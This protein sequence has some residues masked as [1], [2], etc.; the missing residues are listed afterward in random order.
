MKQ[1][2]QTLIAAYLA[3]DP[4]SD[5]L[6]VACRENPEVLKALAELEAV[7]R[8]LYLEAGEDDEEVFA[9]EVRQRLETSEDESFSQ[10][11]RKRLERKKSKRVLWFVPL[12][13][14]AC[15]A[16]SYLGFQS[17]NTESYI[18]VEQA[19]GKVTDTRDAEWLDAVRISGDELKKGIISLRHGYSEI[20][21][22]NGVI[23]VLEAPVEIEIES[24]ALIRLVKGRLVAKVPENA[25]GFTVMTP[26]SEIV[27][28]GTEF[29]MS[30]DDKGASEVHVLEGEV[31]ARPLYSKDF[32]H[33]LQNEAMAFKEK[34]LAS[35]MK[36]QPETYLRSLPG[37][38]SDNPEYLHWSCDEGSDELTCDGAGI[39]GQFF[40]GILKS[41][42]G[43]TLPEY[44]N[45]QFGE[46][47]YFNG[48]SSYVET[49]FSGIGGTAPRTVAFWA[50][51][52]KDFNTRNGY[53]MLGWGLISEKGSAWQISPNPTKKEGPLGRLRMGTYGAPVIGTTDLRDNRWHHIAVVM[54]GGKTANS[55]THILLYVDGR[56]ETT[57]VKAIAAIDTKLAHPKSRSLMMGRNLSFAEDD[58]KIKD[59]FFKGWLDEIFVF[60]TAL[61][62]EQIQCLME[63]NQWVGGK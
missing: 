59:R 5:D 42:E 30:V 48:E 44:A 21:L 62:L 11:V 38:S 12:A 52:P 56:L 50:K 9:D 24:M 6:L 22:E 20:T 53:G 29:G 57:S 17:L 47:L 14:A 3:G 34:N 54:Y 58:Q 2:H 4:V 8:L 43:G 61:E 26:S 23:L 31:K 1:E 27:D 33:L 41:L 15:L 49:E 25:I 7:D 36:S 18:H 13:A 55:S 51:V 45:G 37:R 39:A 46:A 32:T 10:A 63:S 19:L 35:R 16:L 28:L 40:P 60:D